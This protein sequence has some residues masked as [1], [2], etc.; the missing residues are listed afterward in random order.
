MIRGV[1]ET[2]LVGSAPAASSCEQC[3]VCF[4]HLGLPYDTRGGIWGPGAGL[5]LPS[6]LYRSSREQPRRPRHASVRGPCAA[7]V[8]EASVQCLFVGPA[9]HTTP[10][11][12]AKKH[13]PDTIRACPAR[14]RALSAAECRALSSPTSIQKSLANRSDTGIPEYESAT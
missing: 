7:V 2:S 14:A 13:V 1:S 3:R 5:L 6:R 11:D 12:G 9:M 8:S 4:V 10:G